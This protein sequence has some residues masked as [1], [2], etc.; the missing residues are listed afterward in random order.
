MGQAF[1]QFFAMTEV[2]VGGLGLSAFLALFWVLRGAPIGQAVG[3]EEHE[4][5][6]RG[7]Y[8][9]RVVA[10]VAIGMVLILFGG[11]LAVSRGIAWSLP[12]FVLGFG[13][14]FA[15]VLINQRYRH[16]SPT[17]RRTVGLANT[18]LNASLLL[19]VLVVLNVVAFRYGGK[20]IDLTSEGAYTIS[21]LT[22]AQLKTLARP[23]TFTSFFGRSPVAAQQY[24]R[25]QQLL[26]LYK[27]ANPSK[28]KLDHVDP[29]RDLGRYDE[30]VKRVPDIDVTQGGGVLIEYGEDSSPDRVVV[31]NIDLFESPSAARF[32]PNVER[33]ETSFKGENALTFA[34]M[35]LR[36]A[37]KPKVVFLTGHGEPPLE[38]ATANA[39]LGKWRG[40]LAATGFE[41][42]SVNLM[43]SQEIPE[44]AA[45]VIIAGP[46]T[47]FKPDELA[48]LKAYTDR[49]GPVLALLGDVESTGLDP[50]LK[51][52]GIEVGRGFILEPKL[53]YRNAQV[54]VVPVIGQTHPI[55]E[56]LNNQFVVLPRPTS[57]RL[58]NQPGSE[59]AAAASTFA[60]TPLFKTSAQSWNEPDLATRT[61]EKNEKDEAGPFSIAVAVNDR[62]A[63][64]ETRLGT[65]RMVVYSSRYAG[66]NGMILLSPTN[67]DLLMNSVNWLRG[68][69]EENGIPPKIHTSI[70]LS[71]D[72]LLRFK[73]VALPTLF[74]TLAIVAFGVAIYLVRRD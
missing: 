31:R 37:K 28:V 24:D 36:E 69:E 6:P 22:E 4:E 23:V 10:A 1:L 44:D 73:L 66:E 51:P 14:V 18:A 25:V 62:P 16:G 26:E 12:A 13:T 30:L 35:R 47:P 15:L 3:T 63:A 27:A 49:K 9:D 45:I 5:A 61:F 64:G 57:L 29:F 71:A 33:F 58:S 19:G 46:K 53:N 8:R 54:V 21:S 34:L 42:L 59:T 65:P 41:L 2:W 17:L 67:L 68:R 55:L 20:A 74:S 7:G 40:R 50:F 72:P 38:D 56:S 52:F 70:G 32:D 60:L 43:L 11:Y 48:R 39:G